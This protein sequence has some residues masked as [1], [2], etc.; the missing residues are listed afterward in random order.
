MRLRP[1]AGSTTDEPPVPAPAPV[2]SASEPPRPGEVSVVVVAGPGTAYLGDAVASV[3]VQSSPVDEIVIVDG[4]P[5]GGPGSVVAGLGLDRV[6][7]VRHTGP[8]GA[9]LWA[10]AVEEST[11][12]VTILLDGDDLLPPDAVRDVLA[13]DAELAVGD[14]LVIGDDLEAV[15]EVFWGPKS[16]VGHLA[17]GDWLPSGAFAF[18]RVAIERVGSIRPEVETGWF[19]EWL[20]RAVA[21]VEL[22]PIGRPTVMRRRATTEPA[23]WRSEIT[24]LRTLAARVGPAAVM[25]QEA[26]AAAA[27]QLGLRLLRLGDASGAL[28]A[29]RLA[30]RSAADTDAADLVRAVDEALA[31]GELAVVE[32]W[33]LAPPPSDVDTRIDVRDEPPTV[34]IAIPT[35]NR[36]RF[37]GEALDC[38]LAQ[39]RPADEILVID[40]GSTDGTAALLEPYRAAGVRVLTQSNQGAPRTRNRCIIEAEGDFLLW[41]DSDDVIAAD[42]IERHLGRLATAPDAD[43]VYADLDVVD[44]HLR[45]TRHQGYQDWYGNRDGLVA[46]M[47]CGNCVPNG[48][49]MLRRSVLI[50]AGGYDPSF[51]RAHDYE[52]YSRLAGTADFAHHPSTVLKYR[53]HGT[54]ALSGDMQ[55]SDL[56]YELTILH[57]LLDRHDLRTLVPGAGWEQLPD[58][59]AAAAALT[60]VTVRLVRFGDLAGGLDLARRAL[61]L[62]P[63]QP[64]REL[65]ATLERNLRTIG[66]QGPLTAPVPV[67][68]LLVGAPA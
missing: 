37:L 39:T 43:V 64:G 26:E 28:D 20:A 62:V 47:F 58:H 34:T 32:P 29:F 18:S 24:V 27:V 13:A 42:T 21:C 45:V 12:R 8:D 23:D 65:V 41:L 49:S 9:A 61:A 50:E 33:P 5:D 56:R 46:A 40:D 16:A 57:R 30:D 54:G 44:E 53:M 59:E 2:A 11:G 36:A 6:R 52:L 17:D 55:G 67:G 48:S 4:G 15:D 38:A 63:S 14:A 7:H 51:V 3:V 68:P 31:S 35:Y 1:A 60:H 22:T 66:G 10:R 25:G 19:A